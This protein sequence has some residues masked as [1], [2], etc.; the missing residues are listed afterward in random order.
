MAALTDLTQMLTSLDV[1]RRAGTWGYV[2]VPAEGPPATSLLASAAAMVDEEEGRTLVV[3]WE[4]AVDAGVEV[5]FACT[6]L[7]LTVHSALEAVGL[8]AAFST[9]LGAE[10]IPCN[11]LAGAHHD[12]LL[13]PTDRADDAIVALRRLA[14]RS[15]DDHAGGAPTTGSESADPDGG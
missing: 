4:A 12:H 2:S 13:V 11:V 7:T 8:T 10:G 3:P 9:A 14:E 15:R 1:V 5:E 6:W